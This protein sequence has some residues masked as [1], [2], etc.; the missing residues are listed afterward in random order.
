[1]ADHANLETILKRRLGRN[2]IRRLI[3]D[4]RLCREFSG[5]FLEP[6]FLQHDHA[7]RQ[8]HGL[9]RIG[10]KTNIAI[11]I[12]PRQRDDERALGIGSGEAQNRFVTAPRVQR[13]H[14][15]H[16]F[17]IPTHLYKNPMAKRAQQRRPASTSMAIAV[18]HARCGG[19]D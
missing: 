3:H 8:R 19:C 10:V 16:G 7:R 14:Q 18:A 1:M 11:Q 9:F 2:G 15:I 12:R 17:F 4:A 13:E 6:H 5:E